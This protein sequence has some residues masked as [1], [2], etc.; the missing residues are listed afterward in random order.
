MPE[1]IAIQLMGLAGSAPFLLVLIGGA[2]IS[3]FRMSHD[4]GRK[5]KVLAA[6]GILLAVQ[7]LFPLLMPLLLNKVLDVGSVPIRVLCNSLI[8]S[9][10]QSVALG[11]LFWTIFEAPGPRVTRVG[12]D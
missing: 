8:Y 2:A 4:P 7:M 9:V 10:P 5:I 6:I 3:L 1:A 11:L 12:D